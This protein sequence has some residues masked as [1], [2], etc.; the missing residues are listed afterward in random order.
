[1]EKI[2][3]LK[4]KKEEEGKEVTWLQDSGTYSEAVVIK[5]SVTLARDRQLDSENKRPQKPSCKCRH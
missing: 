1:M 4:N 5:N 3:F 2:K